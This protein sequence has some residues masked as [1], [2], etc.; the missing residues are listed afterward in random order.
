MGSPHRPPMEPT[1]A[2]GAH[3]AHQLE[4]RHVHFNVE[5]AARHQHAHLV[6]RGHRV[7]GGRACA[8]TKGG[9]S[10]RGGQAAAS[11]EATGRLQVLREAGAGREG[12]STRLQASSAR[13]LPCHATPL[14]CLPPL[15]LSPASVNWDTRSNRRL[16]GSGAATSPCMARQAGA[17]RG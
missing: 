14:P 2:P 7:A 10:E 11:S 6:K 4:R 15:L 1:P 9:A 17:R 12:R 5:A 16:A 8:Q 13:P 3:L